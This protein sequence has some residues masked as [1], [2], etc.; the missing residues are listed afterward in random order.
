[1]E[2]SAGYLQQLG[3]ALDARAQLLESAQVPQLKDALASY[4]ALFEGAMAM[5]IRK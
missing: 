1:M 2:G 3:S 4:Q 5:L